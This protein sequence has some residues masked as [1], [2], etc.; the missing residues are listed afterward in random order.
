MKRKWLSA[1]EWVRRYFTP[2]AGLCGA[3]SALSAAETNAPPAKAAAPPPPLTP[4]QMFEGGTNTYSNWLELGAGGF[5][6]HGNQP[7]FQQRS[8]TPGTA[9][10]GIEDLHVKGNIDKTTT[11]TVDGRALFN[12]DDYKL[13]IAIER[14]KT[15]YLRFGY[16][17]FRTW[18]NGDGGFYPPS[19]EN[20]PLPG[21]ALALDRGE[22]F[23]EGG[24]TLEKKPKIT[25]KYTH[26]FREGDKGSTSWG[27]V[28]PAGG[29]TVQGL[30][31]TINH[32]DEHGD[33]FQ[34]DITH[35][36][37]ATTLGAGMRYENGKLNEGLKINQYPGEPVQEKITDQQG[38][39][40]DLFNGH[41]SSETWLKKN[42]MLSSG[43]S[44][45][46]VEDTYS[47]SRVYGSEFGAGYT[48]NPQNGFGYYGLSGSA[49]MDDYILDL[50]LFTIPWKNVTII[51]SVRVEKQDWD[52]DSAGTGT[53]SDFTPTTFTG[54]GDR[55]ML[56]VR[57]RLDV[58]Y[59]GITNW[60]L[61]ARGEL[62]EGNGDLTARGGMPVINGIGVSPIQQETDD[63]RLFQKYSAGARW[64]P[65]RRLAIDVGGYYKLD[66][67]G[68]NNPVD[69]TPNGASS[70][71][72]YPGYLTGQTFETYD[73][74]LRVT[75]RPC[76]TVN[77][78]TRY[79][80]QWS[81]VQT[82]PDPIS[83]LP[84]VESSK[85]TSQ[86]LGQDV[87]WTPWSRLYLQA[88]FNYVLSTTTT[89][90]SNYTPLTPALL[91]SQNDYWTLNFSSS[92]VLNDKTD[93]NLGY[94]YYQANNYF[95]NS[96]YGVPYGADAQEHSVSVAIIHRLRQNIRLI[97][98]YG[99]Y[100]YDDEAFQGHR[101]YEAQVVSTS[102]Q[103]RF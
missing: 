2:L 3:V 81:T 92:F 70:F 7:Q 77:L 71:D 65:A 82:K 76:R 25:F 68:Y 57:E 52:A 59:S 19:G 35:E 74:S 13:N 72:R 11:V 97:L 49:R 75:L 23:I 80:Y 40:Y 79:E 98:R 56:D 28:H 95:N 15:G 73:A 54:H 18:S 36:I 86:I 24:L 4:E 102:L 41:F 42:L 69:S 55:G 91:A 90:D 99:Y 1:N 78:V 39:S 45:S 17:E 94:F 62:T 60:V 48:P 34:L 31:P 103:Y 87:S 85:L 100:H 61:Y 44:Y 53:L 66:Q 67:Y 93:L 89:P 8:Q 33:A 12:D 51:P 22:L 50:N 101:S 43:L 16:R 5:I 14:E 64:Y 46:H 37:K 88:G 21:N 9:Y 20:Y 38:T 96:A 29:A 6:T 58:R 83:G 27:Y 26:T 32:I 10:G 30:S 63:Y 47:G 84:E